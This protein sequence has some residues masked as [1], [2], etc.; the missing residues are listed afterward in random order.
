MLA[1]RDDTS[2]LIVHCLILYTS[3][4]RRLISKLVG[5]ALA[6]KVQLNVHTTVYVVALEGW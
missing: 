1:T 2:H 3:T 4:V 5:C 6:R